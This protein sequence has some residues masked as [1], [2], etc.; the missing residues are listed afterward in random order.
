[1]DRSKLLDNLRDYSWGENILLLEQVKST[2]LTARELA[3]QGASHGTVVLAEHQTQ[4]MGRLGRSF[5]SPEG[6]G[7]Y[8]SVILRYTQ[9]AGELLHLTAVAAEAVR[10]GIEEATGLCPQIK[11]INDLL[12]GGKK[13]CGILTQCHSSPDGGTEVILGVG[14]NCNQQTKDFPPELRERA[15]SLSQVLGHPVERETVAG[16]V[17]S[18]LA[19]A[20]EQEPGLWLDSYRKNCLTLGRDILILRGDTT[21]KAHADSMDDKGALLVTLP[22]GSRERVFSGEVSVRGIDG[23]Y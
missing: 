3:L 17:L 1:M 11:W 9:P 22:D 5:S 13:L 6:L 20:M 16:A 14:I 4:G 7:I 15:V 10:R 21:Q 12:I 18:Q 19:L 8:L 23:Y 2:N